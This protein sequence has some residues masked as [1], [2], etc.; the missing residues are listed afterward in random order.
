MSQANILEPRTIDSALLENGRVSLAQGS[1]LGA[2]H[3]SHLQVLDIPLLVISMFFVLFLLIFLVSLGRCSAWHSQRPNRQAGAALL[4]FLMLSI[5]SVE[6]YTFHCYVR[7]RGPWSISFDVTMVLT[8]WSYLRAAL[9]DPGTPASPE[10]K[11]WRKRFAHVLGSGLDPK[12]VEDN[13]VEECL[14]GGQPWFASLGIC[15][16]PLLRF[17]EA[18]LA[19]RARSHI[20]ARWVPGQVTRCSPCDKFRP[21]RSH[22]CQK[23]GTCVLRMDH[24][25]PLLGTCVGWRNHKHFLLLLWWQ[26][27]ACIVFVVAP[28]GP[29]TAALR[30]ERLKD[31][32]SLC[33]VMV[34]N[35]S[36]AWA[37]ALLVIT[38][39]LFPRTLLMALRN[40]TCVESQIGS[41]NPYCKSSWRKNLEQLVGPLNNPLLLLPT[42]PEHRECQGTKFI[43]AAPPVSVPSLGCAYTAASPPSYGSTV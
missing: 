18:Q 11:A 15:E 23:C 10:W 34:L 39:V 24:H 32:A 3:V 42:D 6:W 35:V 12:P 25:C 43:F 28:S 37:G 2:R 36:V 31:V 40:E 21:D 20:K 30:G 7:Q 22:H 8:L 1:S 9:T 38:G 29:L 17:A 14:L 4:L 13:V 27:A 19:L 26:C 16:P 5:F 33:N 41:G